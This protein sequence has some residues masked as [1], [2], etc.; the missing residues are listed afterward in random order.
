VVKTEAVGDKAEEVAAKVG[1]VE[2][3]AAE[4]ARDGAAALSPA[5]VRAAIASARSAVTKNRMHRECVA[6]TRTAPI[7]GQR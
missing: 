2:A 7:A 6:S 5:P 4:E 3:K 1:V